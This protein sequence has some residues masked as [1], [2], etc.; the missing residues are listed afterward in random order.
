MNVARIVVWLFPQRAQQARSVQSNT[1]TLF[2][3]P[4]CVFCKNYGFDTQFLE[5]V[6]PPQ[7]FERAESLEITNS[8]SQGIVFVPD[9][10]GPPGLVLNDVPH[11]LPPRLTSSY[12]PRSAPQPGEE[13]Q[14]RTAIF[15]L[16]RKLQ[17]LSHFG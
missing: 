9:V 5:R 1:S 13:K 10:T 3:P 11:I 16:R 15:G 8:N 4:K 12:N 2:L 6:F 14:C 7:R 17:K